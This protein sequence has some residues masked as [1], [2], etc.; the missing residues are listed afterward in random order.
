MTANEVI[1]ICR[2]QR[3]FKAGYR[4]GFIIDH[5]DGEMRIG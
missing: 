2:A 4:L 3:H 1:H 5:H